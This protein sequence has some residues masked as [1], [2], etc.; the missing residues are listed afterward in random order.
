MEFRAV[1][2]VLTVLLTALHLQQQLVVASERRL[3]Q[4]EDENSEDEPRPKRR[5]TAVP[6]ADYRSFPWAKMLEK[7]DLLLDSS[8]RE[9]KQFRRR[10]RVPYPFFLSLV[11]EVKAGGWDGFTTDEFEFGNRGRRRCIPVE[12]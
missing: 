6:R 12:V 8:S 5:R 1:L 9:A 3:R 2:A 7:H 10:F 11:E 4:A